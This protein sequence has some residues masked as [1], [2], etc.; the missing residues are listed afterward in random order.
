MIMQSSS[1][2]T[3]SS[4]MENKT[5]AALKVNT[6]EVVSSVVTINTAAPCDD[7]IVHNKYI[8]ADNIMHHCDEAKP[9]GLSSSEVTPGTKKKKKKISIIV[10]F[11]LLPLSHGPNITPLALSPVTMFTT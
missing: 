7:S 5:A 9:N 1:T 3:E 6:T 11:D 8:K 4:T 2:W 10:V